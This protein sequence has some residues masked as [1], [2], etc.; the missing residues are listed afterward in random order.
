MNLVNLTLRLL[1]VTGVVEESQFCF[2][3]VVEDRKEHESVSYLYGYFS[4]RRT[5]RNPTEEDTNTRRTLTS[6][7]YTSLWVRP[8][9]SSRY[10]IA[11]D[12]I[13]VRT[14]QL[15]LILSLPLI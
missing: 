4:I 5:M 12:T 9:A 14:T 11:G 1:T 13:R 10:I 3:S 6:G 2:W 8:R 15:R 7:L